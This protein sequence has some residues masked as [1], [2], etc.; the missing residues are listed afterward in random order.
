MPKTGTKRPDLLQVR[1][2]QRENS[3]WLRGFVASWLRGF[4]AWCEKK[5]S[6]R[7]ISTPRVEQ[8]PHL[9]FIHYPQGDVSAVMIIRLPWPW[10]QAGSGCLA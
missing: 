8:H 6:H 9:P 10:A 7:V 3:S 1:W 2:K 5:V 4:V